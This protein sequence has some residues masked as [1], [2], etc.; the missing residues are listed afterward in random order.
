M[1]QPSRARFAWL[2]AVVEISIVAVLAGALASKL[3]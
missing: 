1:P 2:L 3:P